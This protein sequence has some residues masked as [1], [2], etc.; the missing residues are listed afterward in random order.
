MNK[1]KLEIINLNKTFLQGKT[2]ITIFDGMSWGIK[3]GELI[4]IV[5]HSGSGKS[6]LL[7]IIGLL[8]SEYK[9][10]VLIDN[11]DYAKLNDEKK[12]Q[13]RNTKIGFV[14][15]FHHLLPE[16]TALE[17]IAMPLIIRGMHSAEAK[18]KALA[19]L[20]DLELH[21]RANHLPNQLSGGE[22]QRVA[23]GRALIGEPQILLCD[24][25]TGNLDY[26]IANKVF[27]ILNTLIREKRITAIIVTHDLDLAAKTE[28]VFKLTNGRLCA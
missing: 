27:D 6:T 11:I 3:E 2:K 14:Y 1:Y 18:E 5:G 8:D 26:H 22:Q 17:N 28:R 23:I 19:I 4:S 12:S 25:P 21:N 24:E 16:F 15:Q 13:I 7:Q 10:S 9:G 20:D